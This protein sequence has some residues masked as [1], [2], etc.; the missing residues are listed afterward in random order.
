MTGGRVRL[1]EGMIYFIYSLI[2]RLT[3]AAVV[4]ILVARS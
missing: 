4:I 1:S 2:W 3:L